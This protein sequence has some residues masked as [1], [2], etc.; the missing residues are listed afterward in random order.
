MLATPCTPSFLTAPFPSQS[1]YLNHIPMAQQQQHHQLSFDTSVSGPAMSSADIDTSGTF[2][3][4]PSQ[5]TQLV[6][7]NA[8]FCI[9]GNASGYLQVPATS[10]W[11]VPSQPGMALNPQVINGQYQ[12]QLQDKKN[13]YY[14]MGSSVGF[15]SPSFSDNTQNMFREV[16]N[17]NY[18]PKFS[19][20]SNTMLSP[21]DIFRTPEHRDSHNT[22]TEEQSIDPRVLT[23]GA[24]QGP[25]PFLAAGDHNLTLGTR[26]KLSSE[27]LLISSG[28]TDATT[29]NTAISSSF[30]YTISI[31]S[32]DS[33]K[34]SQPQEELFAPL[35]EVLVNNVEHESDSQ[36]D[37]GLSPS[38]SNISTPPPAT[39]SKP[40]NRIS[41]AESTHAPAPKRK[42]AADTTTTG[43]TRPGKQ[44]KSA[45]SGKSDSRKSANTCDV[46]NRSFSR[47]YNLKTHRLTHFPD[48]PQAR[49][50]KCDICDKSFTRKHDMSRHKKTHTNANSQRH[51]CSF[52][53]SHFTR[54]DVLNRHVADH[55]GQH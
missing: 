28:N 51:Q 32:V 39:T 6:A 2:G 8:N 47:P 46:C 27:N 41:E 29:V 54:R 52:C 36:E 9:P 43:T 50:F 15:P 1:K 3:I 49:P 5:P 7:S 22:I 4:V 55:H 53:D 35:E 25:S 30:P 21:A 26:Q 40:E 16:Q 17:Q 19:P 10:A 31:S 33:E 42:R 38:L 24:H 18:S 45:K 20:A 34:D 23:P 11:V 12:Q 48:S 13:S 37:D 14:N 44:Q